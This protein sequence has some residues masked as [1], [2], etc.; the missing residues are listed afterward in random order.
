MIYFEWM[1]DIFCQYLRLKSAG[2][3]FFFWRIEASSVI[4]RFH[5]IILWCMIVSDVVW[6]NVKAFQLIS[7][8]GNNH[9]PIYIW[10]AIFHRI[11]IC[12]FLFFFFCS[13]SISIAC[14]CAD[15]IHNI[16]K[17]K[18]TTVV[19]HCVCVAACRIWRARTS[20]TEHL[21]KLAEQ[22]IKNKKHRK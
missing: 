4:R 16:I 22:Q 14:V 17:T 15:R 6:I 21:N 2:I 11:F 12:Y 5:A 7:T 19:E 13:R 20:A 8:G 1:C 3:G 9:I 18:S 10:M